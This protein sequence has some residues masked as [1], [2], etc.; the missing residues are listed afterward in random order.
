[1]TIS[2]EQRLT[3]LATNIEMIKNMI[4]NFDD[5]PFVSVAQ[6]DA[7]K[8]CIG[9]LLGVTGTLSCSVQYLLEEK[10]NEIN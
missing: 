2:D 5:M 9:F 1:M 6:P 3:D 8:S 4:D 7:I 10:Q